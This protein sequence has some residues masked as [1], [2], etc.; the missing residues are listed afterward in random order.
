MKQPKIYIAG[1][2]SY[3]PR[4]NFPAFDEAAALLRRHGIDAV[5]PAELDDPED[6]KRAMASEDGM[7]GSS[8]GTWGDY[9][10][11]DVKL[12]ADSGVTGI[13]FLSGWQRSRGA[14]LEAFIGILCGLDFFVIDGSTMTVVSREW[15]MKEIADRYQ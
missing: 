9:I 4:F 7:P 5:S 11:R 2:M 1:P 6:R 8:N 10:A 12:I 15:V 13:A 14:K 3:V